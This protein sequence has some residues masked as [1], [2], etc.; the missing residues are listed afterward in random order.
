MVHLGLTMMVPKKLAA[1]KAVIDDGA[2]CGQM[3][4]RN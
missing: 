4:A 3:E 2:G 1:I